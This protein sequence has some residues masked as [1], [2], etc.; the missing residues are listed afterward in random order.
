MNC[1]APVSVAFPRGKWLKLSGGGCHYTRSSAARQRWRPPGHPLHA[2]SQKPHVCRQLPS[3]CCSSF[4]HDH[5]LGHERGLYLA[6]SVVGDDLE[7]AIFGVQHWSVCSDTHLQKVS[8]TFLEEKP[9][10]QGR[11]SSFQSGALHGLL[12]FERSSIKMGSHQEAED[13]SF[14]PALSGALIPRQDPTS[15]AV[16]GRGEPIKCHCNDLRQALHYQ[17]NAWNC[18]ST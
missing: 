8:A 14:C 4:D 12:H 2:T 6:C 10:K 1:F 18:K 17:A 3:V 13:A 16:S 9:L 5:V 7:G 15:K 11:N